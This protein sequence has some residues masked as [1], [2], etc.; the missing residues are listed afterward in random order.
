MARMFSTLQQE[1]LVIVR[2]ELDELQGIAAEIRTLREE[3]NSSP[4][5]SKERAISATDQSQAANATV[6]SDPTPR[7]TE[8][9]A[10]ASKEPSTDV[11]AAPSA[12]RPPKPSGK[13]ASRSKNTRLKKPPDDVHDWLNRR[14]I[15]LQEERQ[16]RWQKLLGLIFG[17]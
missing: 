4:D 16:T 1:Q 15:S 11:V 7:K 5:Q 9:A 17:K 12:S 6:S 13:S 2:K 14:L 8:K 10:A 3:L